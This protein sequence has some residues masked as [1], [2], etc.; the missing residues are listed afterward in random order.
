MCSA[1]MHRDIG[2][3]STSTRENILLVK[4]FISEVC[5][6]KKLCDGKCSNAWMREEFG[7]YT[8][9]I[10]TNFPASLVLTESA[11]FC[12]DCT[13]CSYNLF[14]GRSVC[15]IGTS[16]L[17]SYSYIKIIEDFYSGLH[18]FYVGHISRTKHY[19]IKHALYSHSMFESVTSTAR[20]IHYRVKWVAPV[21]EATFS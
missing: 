9:F 8:S 11:E 1:Y 21:E 19:F 20:K 15:S 17:L 7:A 14:I 4:K 3:V 10:C 13:S 18:N 6:S 16:W 2:D 5:V 12:E